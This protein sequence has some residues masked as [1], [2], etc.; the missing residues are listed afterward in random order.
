M[1]KAYRFFFALS[2]FC[3]QKMILTIDIGNTDIKFGLFD[4]AQLVSKWKLVN[5]HAKTFDEMESLISKALFENGVD[6]RRISQIIAS[7]VV[8]QIDLVFRQFFQ[9]LFAL[10]TIFVNHT[11]DFGFQIDYR[12]PENLGIDRLIAA[13]AAVKKYGKPV[14]VCDF[15]TATTIDA[16]NSENVYLG[17]TIVTGMNVLAE[18]LSQKTAKLPKV[19]IERVES[20]FGK[21]TVGSI[22]A[23]IYFGY[24]GLADGIIRR[25]IDE[26]GENPKIVA[27]GGLVEII[28]GESKLIEIVDENLMF[29]G[30][31]LL[32]EK[33]ANTEKRK[34]AGN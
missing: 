15:G 26:L 13:F 6:S 14:I 27:T 7:S 30:L 1:K 29:D 28:A 4:G 8:P 10:E 24:L 12:Q 11:F 18:A 9:K 3:L 19:E 31:R 25:M 23:G 20:I 34:L 33:T 5:T 21:T 2:L 17:G 32:C 22:K 16:I